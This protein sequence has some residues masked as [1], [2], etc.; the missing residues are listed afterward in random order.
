[1]NRRQWVVDAIPCR[2]PHADGSE[3][4]RVSSSE[5][6]ALHFRDALETR[7]LK[8]ETYFLVLFCN[9]ARQIDGGQQNENVC[10]QQ[11]YAY[12]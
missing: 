10:L 12:M 4:V 2:R 6:L 3:T 1:M 9:R 8:L 5:F 11:R 7:N